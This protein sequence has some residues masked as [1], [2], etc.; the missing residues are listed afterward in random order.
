VDLEPPMVI[1]LHNGTS[2][3]RANSSESALRYSLAVKPR[4]EGAQ[5][6]NFALDLPAA[7]RYL[8]FSR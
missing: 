1:L 6:P 7:T 8:D 4:R 5:K 3:H 2:N